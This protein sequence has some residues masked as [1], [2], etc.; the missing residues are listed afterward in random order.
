MSYILPSFHIKSD[1]IANGWIKALEKVY[2][3]GVEMPNHYEEDLSREA[4]VLVDL[5]NPLAEPKI[6]KG[7]PF[8]LSCCKLDGGSYQ[9][10]ILEGTLDY[11]VDEGSLSYTYHRRLCNWGKPVTKH[12][13]KLIDNHYP[14][15]ILEIYDTHFGLRPPN[16]PEL[17]DSVPIMDWSEGINQIEYLIEKAKEEPISRKL[18]M[19]TWQPHKDLKISGAPCLQ[20][21][22]FRISNKNL[23]MQTCWRSRDLF[24][25]WTSNCI[26]MIE[27]GK[28]IAN[29]LN[30]QLKQYTDFS[31]S[32]HIYGSDYRD[33]ENVFEIIKKRK[34]RNG[35]K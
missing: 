22:W 27:L 17:H 34:K 8:A 32:L 14:Y 12:R 20:R 15:L 5:C 7:D 2:Y 33:V 11:K 31:N 23:V 35:N 26:G 25:A 21:I 18:Q 16:D 28:L 3:N 24:K 13:N 30:L 10:E 19:T 6:H 4:S 1:T 9:K 29:R